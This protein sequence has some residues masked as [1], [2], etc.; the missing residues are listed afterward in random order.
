MMF[1]PR[2]ATIRSDRSH[3]GHHHRS[4]SALAAVMFAALVA[5]WPAVVSAANPVAGWT[6]LVLKLEPTG[7][8]TPH[9]RAAALVYVSM[10]DAINSIPGSCRYS[11]YL[12]PALPVLGASPEA[13]AH[14]AAH[15][16]LRKYTETVHPENS[17]LLMEI[18]T[19]YATS[20]A[21]IP[22]GLG[23]LMGIWAGEAAAE[24]LWAARAH[25]GW[26]N[27]NQLQFVFP[28]PA[29]GVWRPVP[30]WAPGF[31]PPFY[32]WNSV[33]PW[34]L[35]SASQF[36][37]AP[38]PSLTSASYLQD[39]AET[40]AYGAQGSTARTADQSHAAQWWGTCA[41]S[42][43]GAPLMIA[44]QLVNDYGMD[45]HDS[46]RMF[47]LLALTEADAMISNID[48]KNTWNFWRPITAIREGSD[49][50]WTPFL[51]TPPNQ[52]YPA[53]HP[54]VSGA[55]IYILEKFFPGALP[56]PLQVTSE[57]CGPRTFLS[58]SDAVTEVIGARV[59]G[60]MHLRGSGTAGAAIGEDIAGW[61]YERHLLPLG[62]SAQ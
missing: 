7:R 15:W 46:A 35:N 1:I 26:D 48:S 61:I 8:F 36:L 41:D 39:L 3:P 5:F 30:P 34:T 29:P 13:A 42:N 2:A 51:T 33:T 58:L 31:L 52:E 53:G 62:T 47:A 14:A 37:S 25:D 20:L 11:T 17:S 19:F 24:Q 54:M 28:T 60:G 16:T 38:P 6:R 40:Q 44:R 27:P 59:W 50:G 23:K 4:G 55:G 43:F 32:W 10:H 22:E 49:P 56:Q 9:T 57:F 12:P 21:A 18:D 45:L